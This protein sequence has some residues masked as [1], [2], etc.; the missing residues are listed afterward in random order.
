MCSEKITTISS[1]QPPKLSKMTSKLNTT[2]TDLHFDGCNPT[3][4]FIHIIH[5][6]LSSIEC[7]ILIQS[8]KNLVPSNVTRDTV[9]FREQFDD[10]ALSSNLWER[11]RSFYGEDRIKDEDGYSW[12]ATGLNE[13]FRLC[14]YDKGVFSAL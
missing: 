3:T 4:N 14:R 5:D 10:E 9:R 7:H 12:K 11:L 13:R 6:L 2:L 1:S 8:H